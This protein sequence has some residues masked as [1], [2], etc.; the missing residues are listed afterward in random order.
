MYGCRCFLIEAN[1]SLAA[2]LK[3]PGA[4][5]IFPGALAARDGRAAFHL[6]ANPESG[7]IIAGAGQLCAE[8]MDVETVSLRPLMKRLQI[9]RIDLLKLDIEGAEFDL[10]DCTPDDVLREIGQITVEF[11][12]F[13]PRFAGRGLFDKARSRLERAGFACCVMSFRTHGDVLFLNRQRLQVGIIQSIYVR[14]VARF[15]QKAKALYS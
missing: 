13:Q 9:D 10:I 3:V 1:P 15:A 6:D 5:G 14:H 7:S 8:T 12:D 4:S 2:A 11:H